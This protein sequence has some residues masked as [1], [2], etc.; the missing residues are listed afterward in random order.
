MPEVVAERKFV[1]IERQVFGA[2][3]MVCANHATLEQSP[4]RFNRVSVNVASDVF[5]T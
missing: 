1:E 4:E 5:A 2:D 3:L